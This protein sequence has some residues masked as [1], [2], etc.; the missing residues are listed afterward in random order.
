MYEVA[1]GP[2]C[3]E[4]LRLPFREVELHGPD[5]AANA[6]L[7]FDLEAENLEPHGAVRGN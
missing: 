3:G 5:R 7:L 4:L 6:E 1:A 2:E